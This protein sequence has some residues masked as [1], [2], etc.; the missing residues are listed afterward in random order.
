MFTLHTYHPP[1]QSTLASYS[2]PST[3]L[4]MSQQKPLPLRKNHRSHPFLNLQFTTL[5]PA[6]PVTHNGSAAPEESVRPHSSRVEHQSATKGDVET[7]EQSDHK[8]NTK[9]RHHIRT[10]THSGTSLSS[11]TLDLPDRPHKPTK[12]A[13]SSPR[14][15]G[16][17]ADYQFFTPSATPHIISPLS[18]SPEGSPRP[19]S[20]SFKR[21]PHASSTASLTTKARSNST[22]HLNVQKGYAIPP[23]SPSYASRVPRKVSDI[24]LGRLTS[25][26]DTYGRMGDALGLTGAHSD[27]GDDGGLSFRAGGRR[28]RDSSTGIRNRNPW[29]NPDSTYSYGIGNPN[30]GGFET[31]DDLTQPLP[32]AR[33]SLES[34]DSPPPNLMRL[35]FLSVIPPLVACLNHFSRIVQPH[36]SGKRANHFICILW[37]LLTANQTLSISTGLLYRWSIFYPLLPTVIRLLAI[38][39]I[40]WSAT[41]LTLKLLD[42][43][44]RPL[45]C[46]TIIG[47]TTCLSKSIQMWS[48]SNL[49]SRD[50]EKPRTRPSSPVGESDFA[51]S[52]LDRAL[53]ILFMFDENPPTQWDGRPYKIKPRRWDWDKVTRKCIMPAAAIYFIMAWTLLAKSEI[54]GGC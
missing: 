24:D 22:P 7:N 21:I 44:H 3:A 45:V 2:K 27:A 43:Y 36:A 8:A 53:T 28:N 49:R 14:A 54:S 29:N 9:R 4:A 51:S 34:M 16:P 46:W 40:S 50:T 6:T 30:A 1:T 48:T 13:P 5:T 37:A 38:Q 10:R 26:P 15:L 32:T 35:R 42:E 52:W 47:T 25:S 20:R 11:F 17:K 41:H 12:S 33:M 18:Q 31:E 23:A 39:A 19:R